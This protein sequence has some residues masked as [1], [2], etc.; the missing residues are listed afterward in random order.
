[1][2][3]SAGTDREPNA[4]MAQGN[5]PGRQ[6]N[7]QAGKYGDARAKQH[8][9]NEKPFSLAGGPSARRLTSQEHA[10]AVAE[11]AHFRLYSQFIGAHD[12]VLSGKGANKH[13]QSA[14]WQVHVCKEELGGEGNARGMDEYVSRAGSR[15]ESPVWQDA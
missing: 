10:V 12:I 4:I 11:E 2:E 15:S 3:E 8:G 1:M 9:Q 14:L 6:R 5:P 7:K 13:E